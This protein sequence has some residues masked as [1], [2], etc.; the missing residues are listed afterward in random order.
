MPPTNRATVVL[1]VPG[2]PTNT[3]W[4]LRAG[5]LRWLS[6]RS[7][8]TR[9]TSAWCRTSVFTE[10]SPTRLSSSSRSSASVFCGTADAAAAV[11]PAP[12]RLRRRTPPDRA[13]PAQC[14]SARS[15][16]LGEVGVGVRTVMGEGSG[17]LPESGRTARSW[18]AAITEARVRLRRLGSPKEQAADASSASAVA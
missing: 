4:R 15:A 8:A 13:R 10:S 6:A 16:R 18:A 14:S 2:L 9:I 17:I 11:G 12:H 5:D 7:F 1:P 3:R